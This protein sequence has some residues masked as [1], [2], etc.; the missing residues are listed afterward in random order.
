MQH[1]SYSIS[2]L[3]RNLDFRAAHA[4]AA[5]DLTAATE[6][7]SAIAFILFFTSFAPL[8]TDLAL[9]G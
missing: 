5:L 3:K 2:K 8:R 7:C 4:A 9:K 1:I 6:P